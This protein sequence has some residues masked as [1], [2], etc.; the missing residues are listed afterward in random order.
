MKK[1][2][3]MDF[4]LKSEI[5]NYFGLFLFFLLY[6]SCHRLKNEASAITTVDSVKEIDTGINLNLYFNRDTSGFFS[7]CQELIQ[8]SSLGNLQGVDASKDSIKNFYFAECF[9]CKETYQ[10]IF[11]HKD[12]YRRNDEAYELLSKEFNTGCSDYFKNFYCF[13]FVCPMRDPDKQKDPHA[14]NVDFPTIVR[15]Y[16]RMNNDNW[17]FI[18]ESNV[19]NYKQY[20]LLKFKSIYFSE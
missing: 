12:I 17:K 2:L 6:I 4:N 1:A 18:K 14:L 10:V 9:D 15:V 7:N 11:V 20:A 5:S 19:M 3:K 16:K 13:A 8:H